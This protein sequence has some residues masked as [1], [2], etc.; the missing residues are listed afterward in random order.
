[1]K[2]FFN[3][4]LDK[5]G[6]KKIVA[7]FL[8]SFGATKTSQFL[9]ELKSVGFHQATISGLS[10]GFDDLKIPVEKKNLIE[11]AEKN[12]FSSEK[13]FVKGKI[14]AVE[15]YQKLLDIWT[16]ASETLKDDVIQNFQRIDVLNPLYMMAFSGARG[17][18][19]QVRQLVG[20]RGLMSDSAGGIIDF[21]IRRN[22]R[23]GLT[24]TEYAISCYGARK[25]LIDTAL[26]T[27]DSGYLTRRLVDVAHGI[28]I[29]RIEC[30]TKE[31]FDMYPLMTT[32]KSG[33]ESVLLSLEKRIVGRILW[34]NTVE[35][36]LKA[37]LLSVG[38]PRVV[39]EALL[40]R[41]STEPNSL[42]NT[43]SVGSFDEVDGD[44]R[45][46]RMTNI[47]T[48]SKGTSRPLTKSK[49]TTESNQAP[50]TMPNTG[51]IRRSRMTSAAMANNRQ[52]A[53][54]TLDF[55]APSSIRG[56][57]FD[58]VDGDIRLRRMTS[59]KLSQ[60]KDIE[61]TAP[62]AEY[63]VQKVKKKNIHSI[64]IRSPL[65]CFH[66][67]DGSEN[68]CQL[69]YGWSLSHNRLVS[70]GDA[71]GILAAQSIG[72]PGTQLTMRT[73]HTGGIF[74]TELDAKIFA[75]QD[76]Y[77]G[78]STLEPFGR[79]IRSFHGQ[80]AFFL[81]QTFQFK[82]SS[83]IV[84]MAPVIFDR[85]TAFDSAGE[86]QIFKSVNSDDSSVFW[87]PKY[88]LLYVSAGQKIFKQ[89][90]CAEITHVILAKRSIQL[91]ESTET[92]GNFSG[93]LTDSM[94]LSTIVSSN[95]PTETLNP[96]QFAEPSQARPGR[97]K[98][99]GLNK[100]GK[101]K[102]M[103]SGAIQLELTSD[104]TSL[105]AGKIPSKKVFSDIEGQVYLNSGFATRSTFP[106]STSSNSDLIV[107]E[108][109]SSLNKVSSA[110]RFQQYSSESLSGL[111]TQLSQN[112]T[113]RKQ[114]AEGP[115]ENFVR[116][117][118]A[119]FDKIEILATPSTSSND[120]TETLDSV[121]FVGQEDST[122]KKLQNIFSTKESDS[123]WILN[124]KPI[125]ILQSVGPGDFF[126]NNNGFANL[127][128]AYSPSLFSTLS[129]GFIS[130][131]SN[132][133]T[134]YVEPK[135]NLPSIP[136]NLPNRKHRS[137]ASKTSEQN[138]AENQKILRQKHFSSMRFRQNRKA[139]QALSLCKSSLKK[140]FAL[141]EGRIDIEEKTGSVCFP[142]L[143]IPLQKF[144]IDEDQWVFGG[145]NPV[146]NLAPALFDKVEGLVIRQSR[147]STSTSSN[148]APV[149]RREIK[150]SQADSTL[151][152]AH[153]IEPS[154]LT[155]K[156]P[157]L[158]FEFF[159]WK[160]KV[161]SSSFPLLFFDRV[162]FFYSISKINQI[163]FN[164]PGGVGVLDSSNPGSQRLTTKPR[165]AE[166]IHRLQSTI[167]SIDSFESIQKI[168]YLNR[169]T[170]QCQIDASQ[171]FPVGQF[172]NRV[173]I[174]CLEINKGFGVIPTQNP[175]STLNKLNQSINEVQH[176]P[177][178]EP[179]PAKRTLQN[180]EYDKLNNVQ[181]LNSVQFVSG[182]EAPFDKVE[183]LAT[184]STSSNEPTETLKALQRFASVFQQK[185]QIH[186]K[187]F[188]NESGS[189]FIAKRFEIRQNMVSS[190][191]TVQYLN[192]VQTES[193]LL[194][195]SD[196]IREAK[197]ETNNSLIDKVNKVQHRNRVQK[198]V[199]HRKDTSFISVR[200]ADFV[201]VKKSFNRCAFSA[202]SNQKSTPFFGEVIPRSA[203]FAT[204]SVGSAYSTESNE[205]TRTPQSGEYARFD[206]IVGDIRLRRMTYTNPAERGITS[207]NRYKPTN[208]LLVQHNLLN[209][210]IRNLENKLR[211]YSKKL[212]VN[213]EPSK[214]GVFDLSDTT[215]TAKPFYRSSEKT[216]RP[217]AFR[218]VGSFDK[219]EY[220]PLTSSTLLDEFK[221][222][223]VNAAKPNADRY[224]SANAE[225]RM[226]GENLYKIQNQESYE[227]LKLP[228]RW[229]SECFRVKIFLF[230]SLVFEKKR[231]SPD[232]TKSKITDKR[233]V[234]RPGYI[235]ASQ[236]QSVDTAMQIEL[237]SSELIPNLVPDEVENANYSTSSNE[238]SVKPPVNKVQQVGVKPSMNEVQQVFSTSFKPLISRVDQ[239]ESQPPTF[240][241]LT[242]WFYQQLFIRL[243]EVQK[244]K[245]ATLGEALPQDLV[246]KGSLD[247][248]CR[249]LASPAGLKRI[250]R[251]EP[252][253]KPKL[254]TLVSM[255]KSTELNQ[256][257][258]QKQIKNV[259]GVVL[260][261]M[262]DVYKLN[263]VQR[264]NEVQKARS[265]LYS[266]PF[267]KLR[268]LDS[269]VN[270]IRQSR[271]TAARPGSNGLFDEIDA[272][273]LLA[274][275][276]PGMAQLDK[277]SSI[278]RKLP[279]NGVPKID[280]I[281]R[282]VLIS[283]AQKLDPATPHKVTSMIDALLLQ[284]KHQRKLF[285]RTSLLKKKKILGT[286]WAGS[287]AESE[288]LGFIFLPSRIT[289]SDL[290]KGLPKN[291]RLPQ[292]SQNGV[293]KPGFDSS[294]PREF[295]LSNTSAVEEPNVLP[296]LGSAYSMESNTINLS[297]GQ[298]PLKKPTREANSTQIK[299]LINA[300]KIPEISA[301]S[302]KSMVKPSFASST[303]SV[304]FAG[305]IQSSQFK[306]KL[307]TSTY[308]ISKSIKSFKRS[309][310]FSYSTSQ[311]KRASGVVFSA[312]SKDRDP[313][314]L[315]PTY[316]TSSNLNV[317]GFISPKSKVAEFDEVESAKPQPS[318]TLVTLRKFQS[319]AFSE[320]SPLNVQHGNIIVPRQC[321][322]EL[323]YQ[324]SKTG[325]IVQGLPKIE[326]LFEA[327]RTSAHVIQSIHTRLK[328]KFDELS[329]LF[330]LYEATKQS[331]RFIQR[332]LVDEIQLVYQSQGV[333]IGDKHVEIIVRQMTSKVIVNEKGSTSFF[334][335][336]IIDFHR[337]GNIDCLNST[338][339]LSVGEPP[340]VGARFDEVE[341]AISR[342]AGFATN[343]STPS[344]TV[345]VGLRPLTKSNYRATK[346]NSAFAKQYKLNKVQKVQRFRWTKSTDKGHNSNFVDCADENKLQNEFRPPSAI[347][348]DRLN[349]ES[350]FFSYEPI[351]LGVTKIA[352]FTDS[353]ISAASFQEAKRVLM[354][355]ALESR[356]DFLHGLKENVILGR[357]I[358]A[359][360]GFNIE[361]NTG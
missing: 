239:V 352:F 315:S 349:Q 32:G 343:Y 339:L 250:L 143:S 21:P 348:F 138:F 211:I 116:G 317:P 342:S 291:G 38:E 240:V 191:N 307:N 329:L 217:K 351:V 189:D 48:L 33:T 148:Q 19:S 65:T 79:K 111:S 60:S 297:V 233:I 175:F 279:M 5:K 190:L 22:F 231:I 265:A 305:P 259:G 156:R 67:S 84:S 199:K 306:C 327:R 155:K 302:T 71:V 159:F 277:V 203:G 166:N 245:G 104:G 6:T 186:L 99:R 308:V 341:Y 359:G 14:T 179:R 122:N 93:V 262:S 123:L 7:W 61:I 89:D 323:I 85:L 312:E 251:A 147:I 255:A 110:D 246:S 87:L 133:P 170:E 168:E 273:T 149:Q 112:S 40:K 206:E 131:E 172:G 326:Q 208:F 238:R 137:S 247:S 219:D 221:Y 295:G 301:L 228:L 266:E 37:S 214:V 153:N 11:R 162:N 263:K 313:L 24:V 83:S 243:T 50:D 200:L 249:I 192:E 62:L 127:T 257:K 158:N 288:I 314:S 63:L 222:P 64:P 182:H 154:L 183:I 318:V 196:L 30:G 282:K 322:F 328:Q 252:D 74:S 114:V 12:V 358:Q 28:L 151:S 31:G 220:S 232:S 338:S 256:G 46:R 91:T 88:S 150:P 29:G 81:F 242:N 360:T 20:M 161:K 77:I 13:K 267:S 171:D 23:E 292:R 281:Y 260:L 125:S 176:E 43:V 106:L 107:S 135:S 224:C 300:R 350:F 289:S 346:L 27:A 80:T 45:L 180:G 98:L 2:N 160:K 353:F 187:V 173:R 56:L 216:S 253:E 152:K 16:T 42:S 51:N 1:M 202:E 207:S 75:P 44:I 54:L 124:G 280:S 126:K 275:Q 299:Y 278:N 332:I 49:T 361:K 178:V 58:E 344:N 86:N 105:K 296:D 320:D 324:Q 95:D 198:I 337:V 316:S 226:I 241:K 218:L 68:I 285:C 70:L 10:L 142:N 333:E 205:P 157:L 39:G 290:V 139:L 254:T 213:S 325:D 261:N 164:K 177:R 331:I 174:T 134:E 311:Y 230:P 274:K 118:E 283:K 210:N 97:A 304:G 347:D 15:R 145:A 144:L 57:S 271:M 355:C 336:D 117:R 286:C 34:Q 25:G 100:A 225:L 258:L 130:T 269:A 119:P 146:L 109:R 73:F 188:R 340:V 167:P 94:K 268:T 310:S 17:N 128:K 96:V 330:P 229:F 136:L 8:H 334:P 78:F 195:N 215:E 69:C 293:A 356:V 354:Q 309:T 121:P 72:E 236:T 193:K 35:L 102:P 248:N 103:N 237:H 41:Y 244:L 227:I 201:P 53:E 321:L 120:L 76:G 47:S 264:L 165:N 129:G 194:S 18:I 223:I 209:Q 66:A 113:S 335:D 26:R 3:Q 52:S 204:P 212:E 181:T 108:R 115:L 9:E 197:S 272:S 357:F 270:G 132:E 185:V 90:L 36:K 55:A 59:T 4:T 163:C 319:Y 298:S 287:L 294:K 101:V 235:V 141:L 169:V 234:N 303:E 276:A 345:S 92:R 284:G 82:I 184:P 140:R